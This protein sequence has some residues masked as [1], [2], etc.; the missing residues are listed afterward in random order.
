LKTSH[1][2]LGITEAEWDIFMPHVAAALDNVGWI[3]TK[4]RSFWRG[5]RKLH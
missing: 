3:C 1:L 2:G 4:T 5:A